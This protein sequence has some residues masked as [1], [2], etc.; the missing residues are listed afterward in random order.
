MRFVGFLI[1]PVAFVMALVQMAA[2]YSGLTSYFGVPSFIAV[3]AMLLFGWLPVFG[4][5]FGIIGAY[6]VWGM[7]WSYVIL[8]FFGGF[9]LTL[10]GAGASSAGA[11]L[12]DRR[13]KR[14][15]AS[16]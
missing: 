14:Q 4:T 12:T 7:S 8:L 10:L 11:F 9:A 5:V 1:M 16:A 13:M 3:I 2:T 15:Q 6:Y